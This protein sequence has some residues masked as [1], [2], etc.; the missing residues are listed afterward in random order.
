[1]TDS[2]ALEG[3]EPQPPLGPE[4]ELLDEPGQQDEQDVEPIGDTPDDDEEP[5]PED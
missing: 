4:D 1:M 2:E 5:E 3:M